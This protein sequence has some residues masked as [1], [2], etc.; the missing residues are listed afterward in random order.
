M[1]RQLPL[2]P[3]GTTLFPG[4]TLN[5][6]IF[7]ERYR[8]MIARCLEQ[9]SPFGV[10]LIREGDEVEEGRLGARP[11]EPYTVGTAAEI[12]A[13]VRLE[14]GRYLLT[15]VGRER[16]RIQYVLQR[17]PYIIAS[18]AA[19]PEERPAGAASAAAEL[20]ATYERYWQAVAA[21]TGVPA[22][23]EDLPDDPLDLA[24]HLADRLQVSMAR[25]QRWLEADLRTRLRELAADLRAE[26]ALMPTGQR[27]TGE[28]FS[29]M[30]SLN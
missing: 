2:F 28:G 6:H 30:G 24:Y 16:F 11:A 18:V 10:V 29:G 15:A 5:L 19:L 27:K 20:R 9:Q 3:L 8:L 13:N 7:E 1:I 25:K 14:D 4:A 26:L 17:A 12:S 21:A 23:P 22:Q